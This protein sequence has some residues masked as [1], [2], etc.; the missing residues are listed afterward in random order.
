MYLFWPR[1]LFKSPSLRFSAFCE[2]KLFMH[3]FNFLDSVSFKASLVLHKVFLIN[4]GNPA[5]SR[6]FCLQFHCLV[7]RPTFGLCQVYQNLVPLCQ[8]EK[9]RWKSKTANFKLCAGFETTAAKFF[10][11]LFV[12]FLTLFLMTNC[13]P[14]PPP[15]FPSYLFLFYLVMGIFSLIRYTCQPSWR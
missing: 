6:P 2:W 15:S 10:W 8:S 14:P 9:S 5:I 7:S 13:E 4:L 1:I 11:Y 3:R 12:I